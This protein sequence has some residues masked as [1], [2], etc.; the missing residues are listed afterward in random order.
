MVVTYAPISVGVKLSIQARM[1]SSVWCG[2]WHITVVEWVVSDFAP[3]SRPADVVKCQ[4]FLKQ[5]NDIPRK[6]HLLDSKST[7]YTIH[8]SIFLCEIHR[9]VCVF[10]CKLGMSF[11][12]FTDAA[13]KH[14]LGATNHDFAQVSI[15]VE[16]T[17]IFALVERNFPV[18]LRRAW[19]AQES[20]EV[21]S[22]SPALSIWASSIK[23][24]YRTA[25]I[26]VL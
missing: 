1:S 2:W 11:V 9:Q 22:P 19:F 26:P 7:P 3:K 25:Q 24:I 21:V 6:L 12:W 20:S 10:S 17:G 4:S 5:Y 23:F 13:R 18:S 8:I 15:R 16:L 14:E